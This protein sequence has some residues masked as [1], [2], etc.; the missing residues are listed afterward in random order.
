MLCLLP[1]LYPRSAT[2]TGVCFA[3]AF[4]QL[5]LQNSM[6][7]HEPDAGFTVPFQ[8]SPFPCI[9]EKSEHTHSPGC[10]ALSALCIHLSSLLRCGHAQNQMCS[11]NLCWGLH[12]APLKLA[13]LLPGLLIALRVHERS[14]DGACDLLSSFP[15][16]AELAPAECCH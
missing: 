10:S 15:G 5:D 8:P 1:G 6:E 11:W 9:Y 14:R 2:V 7:H 3:G 12:Q 4:P 13:Y 16:G